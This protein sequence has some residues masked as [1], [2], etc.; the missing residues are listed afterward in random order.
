MNEIDDELQENLFCRLKE[1]ARANHGSLDAKFLSPIEGSHSSREVHLIRYYGKNEG[2]PFEYRINIKNGEVDVGHIPT[3]RR[4]NIL[5]A[6]INEV[7]SAYSKSQTQ[8]KT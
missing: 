8:D 2:K 3:H 1:F 5:D 4:N 7:V 6:L